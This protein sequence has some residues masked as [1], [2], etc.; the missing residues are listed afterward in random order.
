MN[1]PR[2]P[3]QSLTFYLL[4]ISTFL[5]DQFT[6]LA[7]VSALALGHSTPIIDGFFHL[8]YVQNFGAAYSLLSGQV[9]FLA[10][11]AAA[12]CIGLI[13]YQRLTRPTSV[14]MV[15]ALG[16]FLGGAMGNMSDRIVFGYVRDMVD[17]RWHGQNVFPIFNVA[18]VVLWLGIGCFLLHAYLHRPKSAM[19]YNDGI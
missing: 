16:F 12:V 15:L 2:T 19:R 11:I 18:D 7:I 14:S 5:L 17:L 8:T 1:R 3:F 13:V 9:W 10:A 6:K 4:A